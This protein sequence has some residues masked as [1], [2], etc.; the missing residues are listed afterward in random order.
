MSGFDNGVLIVDRNEVGVKARYFYAA[1][2]AA[3]FD[4]FNS[5]G[6]PESVVAADKGSLCSDTTNGAFYIKTTD[7]VS[8]GWLKLD[9]SAENWVNVTG[10]SDALE[11]NKGFMANNAGLVTLTLPSTASFGD[12]IEIAGY[13]AGG[14]AV[15]QNA[16]QTI[17]FGNTDTT[18]G[19]GGSLSSTNRY[20]QIEL[21]CT[22]ANTDFVVRSSVGN[23]TIV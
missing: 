19:V 22:V 9:T 5:D 16:S 3:E 4:L 13:G 14:W 23:I 6:T 2:R 20:D 21:L 11:T 18:T 17:H 15:A 7:T 12:I 8:T 10:T 1:G